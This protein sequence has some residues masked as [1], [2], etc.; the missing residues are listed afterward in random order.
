MAYDFMVMQLDSPVTG[1]T[2]VKLNSDPNYPVD[3][4]VLTVVGFGVTTPG[5]SEPN[6]LRKVNVNYVNPTTCNNDYGGQ[7]TPSLMLCAG[8]PNGGKDSCQG[9]SGGPILD[10][11]NVQVGVVSFGDGCAQRGYPGVYSRIS[12][13]LD[14]INQQICTYSSNPPSSCQN[15]SPTPSAS[16]GAV[17]VQIDIMYDNYP[18]E[19]SWTLSTTSGQSLGYSSS[20]VGATPN[21]LAST[22]V[23]L[24]PGSYVLQLQD[25]YGDGFCCSNGNGYYEV[26]A[27]VNGKR[28]RLAKGLGSFQFSKNVEFTVPSVTPVAP[29]RSP[30]LQPV[31]ATSTCSD[32]TGKVVING[33]H[34]SCAWLSIRPSLLKTQCVSGKPAYAACPKLCKAC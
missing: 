6:V 1:I 30:T 7:L 12:G 16:K 18:D 23:D 34:R 28:T 20:G 22:T 29:A 26:Y 9:D 33:S 25:T 17:V 32:S 8:E 10:E 14:W 21:T 3:N 13:G 15:S 24:S 19:T 11:N 4:Q 27:L 2:P 5:G 31:A